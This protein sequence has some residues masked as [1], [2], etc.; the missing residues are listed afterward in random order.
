MKNIIL[1]NFKRF[2]SLFINFFFLLFVILT[3][4]SL[5]LSSIDGYATYFE[6]HKDIYYHLNYIR[7]YAKDKKDIEELNLDKEKY[8]DYKQK[9][10]LNF[11]IKEINYLFYSYK[12]PS[13]ANA[14]ISSYSSNMPKNM[15]SYYAKNNPVTL[16]RLPENK[17]EIAISEVL[18]DVIISSLNI[19]RDKASNYLNN[20]VTFITENEEMEL[21]NYKLVGVFNKNY[22]KLDAEN[23]ALINVDSDYFD[24]SFASE[25][26]YIFI[27]NFSDNDYLNDVLKEYKYA[28]GYGYKRYF[29]L[30]S[31]QTFL[32]D[33]LAIIFM[34]TSVGL[35]FLFIYNFRNFYLKQNRILSILLTSGINPKK[36]I[37]LFLIETLSL[38]ILSFILSLSISSILLLIITKV[39]SIFEIS[40]IFNYGLN[41][42]INLGLFLIAV[43]ILSIF[44]FYLI[45]HLKQKHIYQIIRTE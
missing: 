25:Y 6:N 7:Y 20:N 31:I 37:S 38:M 36:V 5:S 3:F 30:L 40:L 32:N 29:K 9:M 42:V 17:N 23:D 22:L 16:G 24:N 39:L 11:R 34:P 1:L 35:L 33:V 41:I 26:N 19:S 45:N 15:E 10:V 8:V 14:T 13:S 18:F 44:S 12:L 27:P 21:R 28:Q 2:K 43:I 4:T